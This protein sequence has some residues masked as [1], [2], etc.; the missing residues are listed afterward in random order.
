M[1]LGRNEAELAAVAAQLIGLLRDELLRA[2]RLVDLAVVDAAHER[3]LVAVLLHQLGQVVRGHAAL[4]HIDAHIDHRGHER[5][6]VA[7]VVMDD[8]L[9]AML[10]IVLVN[11]LVGLEE[12]LAGHLGRNERGFLRAQSS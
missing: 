9:D 12:E 10:V 5:C 11:A 6:A 4:P 8:Q 2:I 1:R 3:D 7:V